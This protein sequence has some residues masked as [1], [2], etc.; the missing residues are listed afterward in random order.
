L[1]F[2]QTREGT[3]VDFIVYGAS[4]LYA[5]EVKNAGRIRPEDLRPL[6]S[7]ASDYPE[8][9]RLLLYRGRE[10]LVVDGILCLP[11]EEFLRTLRPDQI[12][13]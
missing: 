13:E 1:Y 6:R 10:R 5:I 7:F 3:E 11:C 12:P 8:S 4:G 2:W 9:R